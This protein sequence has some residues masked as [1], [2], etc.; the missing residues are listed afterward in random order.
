MNVPHYPYQGHARWLEHY[1]ELPEQRRLYA[2]FLS[3]LDEYI[4][5]LMAKN[6]ALGLRDDTIVIFQ[7]DHGHSHEE[8]AHFGGGSAGPYRGAKFSLFEG[9]IRVPAIISWPG[10]LPEGKVIDEIGH[11]CD[12]L[13][14]IA[15]LCDVELLNRDI[16][17]KSLA[18]LL[19]G[20]T[21]ESP[22]STLHWT[23]GKSWAVRQGPWKLIGNPRDTSKKAPIPKDAKLFLANLD[24]DLGE[25]KNYAKRNPEVV[26]K[27]EALHR[28][29]MAGV[30]G[31]KK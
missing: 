24:G 7:S 30:R 16:D 9:G 12:W 4:G 23:I 22:H 20:A 10:K 27:L 18:P 6:D 1:R 13:P 31:Q 29:W 11:G 5:K 28:K 25:M 8:R 2:A 26:T 21:E 19:R 15:A 14:T 3:T 17:G